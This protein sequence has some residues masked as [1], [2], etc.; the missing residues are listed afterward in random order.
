VA[1]GVLR[2]RSSD[3]AGPLGT[4][5]RSVTI[6]PRAPLVAGSASSANPTC[7]QLFAASEPSR[8]LG[9]RVAQAKCE[10]TRLIILDGRERHYGSKYKML[11]GAQRTGVAEA[12]SFCPS[13]N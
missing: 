7:S 9:R 8:P 12:T 5:Y 11:A 3:G 10:E 4:R 2:Q 13:V 1:R 6:V